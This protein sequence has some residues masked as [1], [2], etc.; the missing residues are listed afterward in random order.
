MNPD[1]SRAFRPYL[2]R[3]TYDWCVDHGFTPYAVVDV[4]DEVMVPEGYARNGQI[5]LNLSPDA[6]G[7]LVIDDGGVSFQ[8]RFGGV[9]QNIWFPYANLLAL[10]A[11]ENGRGLAFS[12]GVAFELSPETGDDEEESGEP[13]GP[14]TVTE[15]AA[16]ASSDNHDGGDEPPS[17]E[18]PPPRGSHLK[19]V[20]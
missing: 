4:S 5:V 11:R 14:V 10:Y 19:V 17:D 6:T 20:K 16:D 7:R 9:A 1:S 2:I 8:A 13:T 3:A 12:Q 18:D 15:S